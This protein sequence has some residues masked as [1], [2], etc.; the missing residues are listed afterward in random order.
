MVLQNLAKKVMIR[1]SRWPSCP[2][3]VK[4]FKQLLFQNQWANLADILQE[5]Y[6]APPYIKSLKLFPS[7]DK[8]TL[9]GLGKFG[10]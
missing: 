9:S 1:N 6:G 5:A 4:E 8:Q 2:Y 10:K 3:M 7:D